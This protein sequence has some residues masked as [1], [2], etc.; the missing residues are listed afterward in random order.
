MSRPGPL[1]PLGK[2]SGLLP[3]WLRIEGLH[4]FDAAEPCLALW[5]H[6]RD[7][8]SFESTSIRVGGQGDYGK[9]VPVADCE[10]PREGWG[11]AQLVGGM[12]VQVPRLVLHKRT[13]MAVHTCNPSNGDREPGGP[14]S[15]T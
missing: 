3:C 2:S 15:D 4:A 11:A 9:A 8:L 12:K 14:S 10:N 1:I 13:G 7:Q 5:R 6:H